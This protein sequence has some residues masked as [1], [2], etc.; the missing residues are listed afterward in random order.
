MVHIQRRHLALIAVAT[1]GV[2]ILGASPV[3]AH[4][5]QGT[6]AVWSGLMHPLLGPDHIFAMLSVGVLAAVIRRPVAVPAS[7]VLAMVLGGALGMAG[8]PLPGGELAIA[9]SVV[10]LGAALVAGGTTHAA[11]ALALVGAAGFVHGHAHGVEAPYAAEPVAYVLGFVAATA[12]LHAAGVG[13]GQLVSR[14]PAVRAALG[15]VVIGAGVAFA[16]GVV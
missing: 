14:R 9:L 13:A 15:S 10:A 7:F 6:G 5:G 16:V 3:A 1:F 2:A 12:A 11:L 4:T 8:M